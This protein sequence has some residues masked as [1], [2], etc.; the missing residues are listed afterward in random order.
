MNWSRSLI[1]IAICV[2]IVFL[3]A[4]GLTR[5]PGEIPSPLP[6]KPA[7]AFALQVMDE[8]GVVSLEEH[9]GKVVVL[10]FWASWC[11]QCRDEHTDLSLAANMYRGRGVE[12]YGVLY[13]D[14]PE[15]GRRW[16]TAMGGQSY[17]ALLDQGSRT[18][19][20]YGLYG[21]PETFIID[22]QGKV[23]HKKIGPTTVAELVSFIDPLL[24]RAPTEPM[25]PTASPQET[26]TP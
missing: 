12:F 8:E 23:V 9:R 11:L 26:G 10:N 2:P 19:I 18:A 16:L 21:V 24:E 4:F 5:D 14:T 17:P 22:Q 3:L 20:E 25:I 15:N 13:N 6:G 7:P 1:A